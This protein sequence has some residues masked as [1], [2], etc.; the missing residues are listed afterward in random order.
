MI[1]WADGKTIIGTTERDETGPTDEIK[2]TEEDISYLLDCAN[3]FLSSPLR[4]TDV[5]S[6]FIGTRPL[7]VNK[8]STSMDRMSR[9]YKLDLLVKGRT[10]I[11]HVYGGKLTTCLSLADQAA[12]VLHA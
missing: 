12:R 4:R 6:A 8:K 10:R 1:P 7:I 5:E 11:L 2:P 9:E 3:H